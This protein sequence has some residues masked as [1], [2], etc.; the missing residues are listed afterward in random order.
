MEDFEK[1]QK[2]FKEYEKNGLVMSLEEALEILDGIVKSHGHE[3]QKAMN[4][5][6]TIGKYL[7]VQAENI[8]AR[9]NIDDYINNLNSVEDLVNFLNGSL[10][11]EEAIKFLK[12][13]SLRKNYFGK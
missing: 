7:D 5:K 4:L 9:C 13:F 1:A 8:C 11:K 10:S 6:N 2:L 12:L 3:Y